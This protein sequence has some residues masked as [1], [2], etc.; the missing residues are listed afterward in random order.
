MRTDVCDPA[1][2]AAVVRL[3][4]ALRNLGAHPPE[5][6]WGPGTH[7]YHVKIS[8]VPLTIFSNKWSIDVEGPDT[9]VARLMREFENTFPA[10]IASRGNEAVPH[11]PSDP[12]SSRRQDSLLP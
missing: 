1:D 3:F 4:A 5:K 12:A 11:A 8:G 9:V 7:V 10:P 6:G 2:H